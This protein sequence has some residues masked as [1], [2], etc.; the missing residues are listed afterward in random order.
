[1][2]GDCSQCVNVRPV[3]NYLRPTGGYTPDLERSSSGRCCRHRRRTPMRCHM[4]CH[5]SP[6]RTAGQHSLGSVGQAQMGASKA[7]SEVGGVRRLTPSGV[8]HLRVPP[9]AR[10]PTQHPIEARV[11][12]LPQEPPLAVPCVYSGGTP[13]ATWPPHETLKIRRSRGNS[14][15]TC[16]RRHYTAF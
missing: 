13:K 4:R 8:G 12:W 9:L 6:S 3:G 7:A 16:G 1:L 11:V 2:R 15:L 5:E 10:R 14:G